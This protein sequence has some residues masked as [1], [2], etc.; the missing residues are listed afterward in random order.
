MQLNEGD[1]AAVMAYTRATV[2]Q[3]NVAPAVAKWQA[4]STAHPNDPR[5]PVI[6]G[7]LS[8]A[9]GNTN[10]AMAYYKKALAI[11]PDRPDAA[12][13]LAYL[14]LQ[15]GQDTDVALSLAQT[16]RRGMPHSPNTAD[17]LAWAYYKKGIYGTARELLQD[18]EKTA[19]NN[20]SIEYHM[21]MIESK[22]GDKA[23]A[24]THLKKAVSLAPGSQNAK[25]AA[26]ALNGLG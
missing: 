2:A 15:S 20:A 7:T 5:A 21:G 18:A 26:Q 1:G 6:L 13:N 19:P 16:A 23:E 12:N 11:Q 8:E 25:D 10:A 22:L 9:Q 4:W 14:M 17:T 3:G 24:I